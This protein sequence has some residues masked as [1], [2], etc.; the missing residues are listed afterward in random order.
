MKETLKET[1]GGRMVL[2]S[3]TQSLNGEGGDDRKDGEGKG[4]EAEDPLTAPVP[5]AGPGPAESGPLEAVPG[6]KIAQ[7]AGNSS[8]LLV[9]TYIPTYVVQSCLHQFAEQLSYNRQ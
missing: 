8:L 7:A 9:S 3:S 4:G 5:G 2:D 1:P 6:G